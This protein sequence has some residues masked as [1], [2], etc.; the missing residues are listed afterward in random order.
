MALDSFNKR[1]SA[2][3]CSRFGIQGLLFE[4]LIPDGL[5]EIIASVEKLYFESVITTELHFESIIT[6][7]LHFESIL[8]D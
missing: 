1:I 7:G 3:S 8:D 2:S 4:P 5:V 6:P